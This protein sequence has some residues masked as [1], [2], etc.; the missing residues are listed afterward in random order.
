MAEFVSGQP[1]RTQEV[2]ILRHQNLSFLPNILF[3]PKSCKQLLV[4]FDE[5]GFERCWGKPRSK[6][7]EQRVQRSERN[8]VS[9][10]LFDHAMTSVSVA[11]GFV[12]PTPTLS[13]IP[14]L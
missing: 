3:L 11:S 2:E 13:Q 8:R 7:V 4:L 12:N 10:A 14:G 9:L 6:F 5:I 1:H